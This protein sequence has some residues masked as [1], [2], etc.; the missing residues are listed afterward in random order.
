VTLRLAYMVAFGVVAAGWVVF[1]VTFVFRRGPKREQATRKSSVSIL[2]IA[3]Q[4][5]GFLATCML[6]RRPFFS[7]IVP[8]PGAVAYAPPL[9]AA[10]LSVA[11]VWLSSAAVRTLGK[12]WSYEARL[13]EGH[14]LVIEGPYRIVRHPI[15]SAII[16]KLIAIGIVVS[17]WIGLLAGLVLI[18]IGT[19]IRVRAEENLLRSQFGAEYDAYARRVPGIVPIRFGAGT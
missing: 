4:G 16:G 9:A 3:I 17:H 15:Y 5:L 12:E 19:A 2:G 18:S 7:P 6:Q 10:A 8:L 14:R 1:V 11:S 13:V